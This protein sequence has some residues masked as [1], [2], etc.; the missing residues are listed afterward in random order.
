MMTVPVTVTVTV[1]PPARGPD[2]LILKGLE[3][4]LRERKKTNKRKVLRV[5]HRKRREK[6]RVN[7]GGRRG[8][9]R[10]VTRTGKCGAMCTHR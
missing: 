5:D 6:E 3:E 7:D 8:G 2:G 9:P 10:H 1:S 4:V